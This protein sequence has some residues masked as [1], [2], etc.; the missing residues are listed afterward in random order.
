MTEYRTMTNTPFLAMSVR[1][2]IAIVAYVLLYH[3]TLPAVA[4]IG[5]ADAHIMFAQRFAVHSLFQVLTLL[6]IIFYRREYGFLHPLI[7]PALLSMAQSALSNP[8]GLL[9]P[10]DLPAFDY[11]VATASRALPLAVDLRELARLRLLN[12]LLKVLGLLAYFSGFFLLRRMPTPRLNFG[13][14]RRLAPICLGAALV[15]VMVGFAFI[16]FSQGGL[17]NHL[18]AMRGGRASLFAGQGPILA[19][20]EWSI[21]A[22]LIWFI[23]ARRP[24]QNPFWLAMFGLSAFMTLVIAGSR[25]TLVLALVVLVLL[26]WQRRGRVLIVPTATAALCALVV[27]GAFG[28]VRM[29]WGSTTIDTSVLSPSQIAS[30]IQRATVEIELRDSFDG[31]LAA[32]AGAKNGLLWGR[33]YVAVASFWIPRAIWKEKPHGAGAYN[34]WVNFAGRP[35][36][37]FGTGTYYGI[38]M[39]AVT[40]AYWNLHIPGV[41]IVMSLVG[42]LHRWLADLVLRYPHTPVVLLLSVWITTHFAGDSNTL[43][44]TIRDVGFILAMALALGVLRVGVPKNRSAGASRPLSGQLFRPR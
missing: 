30:N 11:G 22:V 23:Y 15:C 34:M 39:D 28:S 13:S 12:E 5:D 10:L 4:A 2:R 31:D 29:D 32:F 35:L 33:S 17:A 37:H 1:W 6:P 20:T 25:S 14:P 43:I 24:F 9:F 16:Q 8:L 41:L 7:L 44:V 19:M 3:V 26:W 27:L 38:P 18:I 21:I 36:E 40:E 42:V